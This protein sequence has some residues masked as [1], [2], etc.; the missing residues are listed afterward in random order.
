MTMT[1]FLIVFVVIL[2]ALSAFTQGTVSFNLRLSGTS[3][4]YAPRLG[5]ESLAQIGQG[6]NDAVP[7]GTTDWS[8]WTAIGANGLTGQYGAQ[9]TYTSL[10][11]GPGSNAAESTL[12]PGTLNFFAGGTNTATTFRTGTTA[13]ANAP[14]TAALFNI[15]PDATIASFEVVAWDNSS[16]NYSTWSL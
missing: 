5:N 4:V 11:G 12:L 2:S 1:N 16:G 14:A 6:S 13:G 3:H 9:N 10:L 8:G 15:P 7:S